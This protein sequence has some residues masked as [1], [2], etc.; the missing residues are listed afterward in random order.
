MA[1]FEAINGVAA[2][3]IEAVSGVA[4]SSMEAIG[5]L[6]T[7]SSGVTEQASVLHWW[8]M[9]DSAVTQVDSIV[10]DPVSNL[11]GVN[12]D[13]VSSGRT[14]G[15]SAINVIG[16]NPVAGQAG[17]GDA[18]S[19]AGD[20][21]I[22]FEGSPKTFSFWLKLPDA[23][24]TYTGGTYRG[25]LGCT[26]NG[27]WFDGMYIYMYG[28]VLRFGVVDAGTGTKWWQ[29]AH[30]AGIAT[31]PLTDDNDWHHVACVLDD[32]ADLQQIYMDGVA[33]TAA[34]DPLTTAV[35]VGS[36]WFGV[37]AILYASSPSEGNYTD[38]QISDIRIYSAALDATQVA[39][40]YNSG[41]G[42]W[43]GT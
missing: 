25:I 16:Y 22:N 1:D 36:W 38:M 11:T 14:V 21:L 26:S 42:D 6:T 13:L 32:G 30:Y 27:A 18:Y 39:A 29:A 10:N 20:A 43:D 28:G 12:A 34:S 4:K 17:T 9:N 19:K 2:G 15:G 5:G 24:T 3:S 31:T 41:D 7:P 8:K 23:N 33:G 40:V 35:P 37:G